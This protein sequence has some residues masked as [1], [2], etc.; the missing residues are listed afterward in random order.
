MLYSSPTK[1]T[2]I[3]NKIIIKFYEDSKMPYIQDGPFE[4]VLNLMNPA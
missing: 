1:T 3:L 2:H 4:N